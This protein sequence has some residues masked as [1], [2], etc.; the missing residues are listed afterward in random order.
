MNEQSNIEIKKEKNSKINVK[1]V[2]SVLLL[3]LPTL[4]AIIS[5]YMIYNNLYFSSSNIYDITLYGPHGEL[6]DSERNY[7]R[8]AE[9]DGLV[10]LFS[11]ITENF[12]DTVR[13]PRILTGLII[14]EPLFS[15]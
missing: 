3:I 1:R 14:S 8:N 12:K 13:I 15:I 10:S 4:L 9:K 6:I 2:I 7:L 11:P 5:F